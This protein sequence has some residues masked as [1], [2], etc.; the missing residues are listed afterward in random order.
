VSGDRVLAAPYDL[1]YRN[2]GAF[3][4]KQGFVTIIPDYRLV[5]AAKF[6]EPVEDVRDAIA[7]VIKNP[8]AASDAVQADIETIFVH[9]H[10]AGSNI[11]ATM[12]LYPD[13]LPADILARIRGLIL[14]GGAYQSSPSLRNPAI[15]L[16][17]GT[18][19][20]AD[21]KTPKVLLERAPDELLA[22]FPEVF[23]LVSEKEP[24][25]LAQGNEIFW[26]I[27]KKRLGRDVKFSVMKGHN[28]ISPHSALGTGQGDEWG[29][30]VAE[31]V[32]ALNGNQVSFGM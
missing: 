21:E 1:V 7:W 32:H 30:E 17:Y 28:H 27:L 19:P 24:G 15:E 16:Y 2:A 9:G 6:P 5:P 11:T 8:E 18:G 10:S 31:W 25:D 26:G 4:A 14:T 29:Y 13:L 3:F 22:R 20:Q 12:A 23:M